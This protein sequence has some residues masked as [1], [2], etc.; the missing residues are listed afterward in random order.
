MLKNQ[1][2]IRIKTSVL[3]L[4]VMLMLL[5]PAAAFANYFNGAYKNLSISNYVQGIYARIG[6]AKYPAVYDYFSCA[7]PMVANDG[8]SNQYIQVGWMYRYGTPKS[9]NYFFEWNNGSPTNFTRVFSSVGPAEDSTHNYQVV[10]NGSFG[11][12][13]W[14]G[15]V[16][17]AQI[18]S[19]P[20]SQLN[21]S[22]PTYVQYFGEVVDWNE[23]FPGQSSNH[24]NFS[25]VQYYDG[26]LGRWTV[27]NLSRYWDTYGACQ[28]TTGN[29]FTIWDTRY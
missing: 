14:V 27:P 26:G 22:P 20:D 9:I 28:W 10:L 11:T 17:S 19:V 24:V 4:S 3:L 16:D 7:W 2:I 6:T 23:A 5:T 15:T 1:G 29:D 12:G 21:W 18:G 8:D 25:N 13:T